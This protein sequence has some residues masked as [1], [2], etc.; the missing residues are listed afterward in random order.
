MITYFLKILFF[1]TTFIIL[2]KQFQ[3]QEISCGK[4]CDQCDQDGCIS[5]D[6]NSLLDDET[7]QCY[8]Q[9]S[10][11]FYYDFD[12]ET[13]T[14]ICPLNTIANEDSITCEKNFIIGA[15]NSENAIRI[16]DLETKSLYLKLQVFNETISNF[17]VVDQIQIQNDTKQTSYIDSYLIIWS[18]SS[19]LVVFELKTF[20]KI[21]IVH[22]K[23]TCYSFSKETQI[24][25]SMISQ[26][27]LYLVLYDSIQGYVRLLKAQ[28]GEI[29]LITEIVLENT[30]YDISFTDNQTTKQQYQLYGTFMIYKID[31]TSE[32]I[33][34]QMDN[35]GQ[36]Q[37]QID[38][39]QKI[40][41]FV[42]SIRLICNYKKKLLTIEKTK[43]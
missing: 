29:D 1:Y 38:L 5:C 8:E 32:K 13:C 25:T 22:F 10:Y 40:D 2:V 23:E 11:G 28:D 18:Q 21:I 35:L 14:D 17:I 36:N 19:E 31:L 4:F 26:N 42:T 20:S 12:S 15:Y 39:K 30:I 24:F 27:I 3:C 34:I 43:L 37:I 41:F 9:C 33:L 7:F 16:W 6:K